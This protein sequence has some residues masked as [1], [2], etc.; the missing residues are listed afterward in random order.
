M[1]LQTS[2][3]GNTMVSKEV[4]FLN[5]LQNLW[6]S[7]TSW[8]KNFVKPLDINYDLSEF[9]FN[10]FCHFQGV[11]IRHNKDRKVRRTAPKSDDI[12]LRLLVKLY[13]FLARRTDAK[14][15][16]IVLR[17]LF[18]SKINRPP[19]S[20]ARLIRKMKGEDRADKIAVVVGT[21]TNDLRIFKIPK[22]KVSAVYLWFYFMELSTQML[23]LSALVLTWVP[24]RA[25]ASL[26][27]VGDRRHFLNLKVWKFLRHPLTCNSSLLSMWADNCHKID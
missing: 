5:F 2:F 20:I 17:R 3:S 27:I 13:R 24:Y 6:I 15:N 1:A 16:D 25:Q 19:I 26:N 18:M 21:V 11:D 14:F 12:Y 10:H 7:I 8:L 22:L 9:I 4:K 23:K